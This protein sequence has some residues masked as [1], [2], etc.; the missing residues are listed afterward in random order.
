M[1]PS[2]APAQPSAQIAVSCAL[3]IWNIAN[4]I[5]SVYCITMI[6][7]P[8]PPLLPRYNPAS[9]HCGAGFSL[10][11]DASPVMPQNHGGAKNANKPLGYLGRIVRQP[12]SASLVLSGSRLQ[13]TPRRK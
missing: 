3:L 4:T 9:S 12:S 1:P 10:R 5:A 8:C 6:T 11:Y 13:Q 7:Q 2:P